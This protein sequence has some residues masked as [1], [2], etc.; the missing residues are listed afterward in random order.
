VYLFVLLILPIIES[1]EVSMV[2]VPNDSLPIPLIL[3]E[4]LILLLVIFGVDQPAE[5]T[6]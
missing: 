2:G 3:C 1:I 6:S 4:D 5:E